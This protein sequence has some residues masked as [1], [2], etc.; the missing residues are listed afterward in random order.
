MKKPI[1]IL[2]IILIFISISA[3][4]ITKGGY[5]QKIMSEIK[6]KGFI[7]YNVAEAV[8]M[9]T[10]KCSQCH[11]I[12]NI[13]RYCDRCGPPFIVVVHNMRK[14]EIPQRRNR[15]SKLKISDITDSQAAA[16]VQ[17]WNATIGNW[18]K[19]FRKEDIERLLEGDKP[20]L[21]L[22]NTPFEKRKIENSLS[23][24]EMTHA[25]KFQREK[26]EVQ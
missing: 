22:L 2:L 19:G 7:E 4:L 24:G 11:S 8:E 26:M 20:L 13:K 14:Y 15:D 17:V 23:N 9:A 12:D 10:N 5:G 21:A 16:I 1:L 25:E 3:F 6:A 18:E